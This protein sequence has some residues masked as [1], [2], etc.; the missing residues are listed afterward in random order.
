VNLREVLVL[1]LLVGAA[2][3]VAVLR[4]APSRNAR[5]L[6]SAIL[7]VPLWPLWA[8]FALSARE[9]AGRPKPAAER[10]ARITR[11]LEDAVAAVAESPLAEIF[12]TKIADHIAAEVAQ[13]NARISEMDALAARESESEESLGA[14]LRRLE[15]SGAPERLIAT[16]RL[17]H[18][19]RERLMRTRARDAQALEELA[20]LLDALRMQLTLAR[21]AG[22]SPEG[23]SALVTEVWARL[24]GLGAA[25]DDT[26]ERA[27]RARN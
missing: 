6:A 2:C 24:D 27:A 17:A 3:S 26:W 21:H 7:T 8:P 10:T 9:S 11:A 15:E 25:F 4:R 20:D 13:V 22:S 18:E 16:A 14:R 12:S 1:Y 19:S 5:T 23:V